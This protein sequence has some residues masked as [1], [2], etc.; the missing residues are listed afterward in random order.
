MFRVQQEGHTSWHCPNAAA[1]ED[2]K[3]HSSQARSVKKL[4]KDIKSI[5]KAFTQLQQKKE[6]DSDDSDSN[7]SEGEGDGTQFTQVE[8]EFTPQIAKL[9]KQ[10]HGTKIKLDLRGVIASPPW[11]Y[12]AIELS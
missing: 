9:F 3:S 10:T 8:H 12:F 5:K 4:A 6:A 2:E 11:I 1:D 7:A